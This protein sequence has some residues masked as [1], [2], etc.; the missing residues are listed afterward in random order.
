MGA[1]KS[2]KVLES[3]H[4]KVLKDLSRSLVTDRASQKLIWPEWKWNWEKWMIKFKHFVL[5]LALDQGGPK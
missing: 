3:L 1:E 5:N 4:R 2:S